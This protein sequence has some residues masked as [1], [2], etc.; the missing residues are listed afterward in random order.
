[1]VRDPAGVTSRVPL[2]TLLSWAWIAFTIEAD[3][4]VEAAGSERV[5]RLFRISL[6]MW[7]NGLRFIGAD[8]ISAGELRVRARA[9]CNIGGL[10]RWGWITVGDAG[11]G[12]RD[13]YGSHRGV[14]SGTV[15]RVTRAGAY[16]RRLWPEAVAGVEQR[17]RDRFGGG[18]VDS[19][20]DALRRY[21]GRRMPSAPP[22]VHP[23]DGFR[24]HVV[25]GP[26]SDDNGWLAGRLGQA[27]TSLTLDREQDSPVS[28]PVAA[29]F[30]RVIGGERVRIR[31]L[32]ALSGVS[33]EAVAM[34]TGYLGRHGLA[35]LGPQR[36]VTLA[37]AGRGA[38][39][40]YRARATAGEDQV[41][42]AAL[43]AV[44]SRREALAGGLVPPPGGWR[45]EK[46]YLAQTRRVLADPAA[47][48]PW[49]PMVLHRGGWPDGS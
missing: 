25:D 21:A 30:L 37:A 14:K 15:L 35:E 26:H 4:A 47:A 45:G 38:L 1:M 9:A 49:H 19:L 24:T 3:N 17:W 32:P 44:V 11:N 48:L 22:E 29:N 28:L 18:V 6:P 27:L 23:S 10:E 33:R 7:A 40:D 8:G 43:E 13:G 20:R 39:G 36:S 2:T 34:A 41:L 5:G 46:P 31:D 12:R 16:A 42:R